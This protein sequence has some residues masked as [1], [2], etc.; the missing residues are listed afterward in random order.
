MSFPPDL[1]ARR[2]G[3]V[4]AA[5]LWIGT[6]YVTGGDL[7][8][9]GA[10]CLGLP[11][12]LARALRG[13]TVAREPFRA[14]WSRVTDMHAAASAA[15]FA[16]IA[17]ASAAPGDVVAIRWTRATPPEHLAIMASE[18]TIIHASELAG[19]VETHVGDLRRRIAAAAAFPAGC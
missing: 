16:P 19:V 17:V 18:R 1:E 10:D 6:P 5:R 13:V 9:V 7:R 11:L 12:G 4:A 2:A 15:G 3:V 8:G 14:D